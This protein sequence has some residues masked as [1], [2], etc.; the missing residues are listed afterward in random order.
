MPGVHVEEGHRDVR[1]T[2]CLLGEAQQAD[3]IFASR[4]KQCGPLKLRCH[5]T[6][7]VN[8]LGFEM[9]KMV[10]VVGTHYLRRWPQLFHPTPRAGR[11]RVFHRPWPDQNNPT[12]WADRARSDRCA[13]FCHSNKRPG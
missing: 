4:K 12:R 2:E 3:G 13:Y 9:L 5:L 8:G 7:Y 11:T 1:R 10:E 6:H